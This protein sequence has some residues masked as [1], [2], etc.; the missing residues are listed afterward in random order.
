M[1]YAPT[2][3][4][5]ASG[6]CYRQQMLRL[7][8][9]C[10]VNSSD[11]YSTY[12]DSNA[13]FITSYLNILPHPNDICGS[14]WPHYDLTKQDDFWVYYSAVSNYITGS[15][16]GVPVTINLTF[17]DGVQLNKTLH[18]PW[19]ISFPPGTTLAGGPQAGQS[20]YH[21]PSYRAAAGSGGD[22]ELWTPDNNP[23][24]AMYGTAQSVY[25][26]KDSLII[27]A[28]KVL[29][30]QD[31]QVEFGQQGVVQI[32]TDPASGKAGGYLKLNNS[33]LT[34]MHDCGNDSKLWQG[35]RVWG[36]GTQTQ[37]VTST[38]LGV[39]QSRQGTLDMSNAAGISYAS[40]GVVNAG[41]TINYPNNPSNYPQNG[42]PWNGSGGVILCNNATFYNN[43]R[44]VNF[45]LYPDKGLCP[46]CPSAAY[47]A[48]FTKCTFLE[49]GSAP[50]FIGFIGGWAV[51]GVGI[52]G[53]TF[54]DNTGNNGTSFRYGING[55]DFGVKVDRYVHPIS[56]AATPT[57]FYNLNNGVELNN[58]NGSPTTGIVKNCL[59][60]NN[61]TGASFTAIPAPQVHVNT[62]NIGNNINIPQRLG[63]FIA[64]GSGYGVT[65]NSFAPAPGARFTVGALISNTGGDANKVAK[66]TYTNIWVANLSNYL[67][68]NDT[69]TRPAAGLQF[70]CNSQSGNIWDIAASGHTYTGSGLPHEGMCDFQGD[71]GKAAGNTFSGSAYYN[72]ANNLAEVHP[73]DYYAGTLA[74]EIP[75][76][77]SGTVLHTGSNR[78]TCSTTEYPDPN[79]PSIIR[80]GGGRA[81]G[82]RIAYFLSDP[83]GMQYR[84]SLYLELANW[85]SA[86]SD[87]LKT[88]MLIQDGNA[89]DA[90]GVYNAIVSNDTLSGVETYEFSYWGRRL[91]DIKLQQLSDGVTP[92]SLT[93]DQVQNLAG[94]ADSAKMWARDRA[95]GWL[96]IYDGRSFTTEMVFPVDT[97]SDGGGGSARMAPAIYTTAT[98]A[99]KLFYSVSPNPATD[100]LRISYQKAD[101]ATESFILSDIT[102]RV[103]ARSALN[104]NSGVSKADIHNLPSGV[105][106][107]RIM[108]GKTVKQSGKISKQ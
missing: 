61:N 44:A 77:I 40:W 75:T 78:N 34:A 76:N 74:N 11:V 17:T 18:A 55:Y 89:I 60:D 94:I 5:P 31:M 48:F 3:N 66:N 59:F 100:Q 22:Y 82:H 54:T 91:M 19:L 65:Y 37:A 71:A 80:T 83:E 45:G 95:R 85:H 62:F 58:S 99:N 90:N 86:Y 27:P 36:D 2:D 24:A 15:Q 29:E 73:V 108:N 87:L 53:S 69:P 106:L 102:G 105:Y 20:P 101:G 12:S 51:N 46:T 4:L 49:D 32:K 79:D 70:L 104:G 16:K 35:V 21:S 96:H 57:Q 50:S 33:T 52:Y 107:Y 7:G 47:R 97:V 30:I 28:G 68:R 39:G 1:F 10:D 14:V 88:D 72:V 6:S 41:P 67:N 56:G 8:I 42:K 84:D 26:I 43:V 23:A 64:T 81:P 92:D 103:V 13:A 98:A 38:A 93:T 63:L 25:K 9:D